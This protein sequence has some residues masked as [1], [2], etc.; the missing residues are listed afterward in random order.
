MRRVSSISPLIDFIDGLL[1]VV[2]LFFSGLWVLPL[3]IHLSCDQTAHEIKD[4]VTT[5]FVQ[6]SHARVVITVG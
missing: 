3:Q 5:A 6:T 1:P 2:R 4:G